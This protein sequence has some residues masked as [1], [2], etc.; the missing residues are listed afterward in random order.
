[1]QEVEPEKGTGEI[2]RDY[3]RSRRAWGRWSQ[4]EGMSRV[5]TQ[6]LHRG[7]LS[8]AVLPR[9]NGRDLDELPEEFRREMTLCS[10]LAPGLIERKVAH[11][12][13]KRKRRS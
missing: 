1:M 5:V 4:I 11:F 7:G 10:L 12:E 2:V 6:D 13:E 3:N 9:P 8:K